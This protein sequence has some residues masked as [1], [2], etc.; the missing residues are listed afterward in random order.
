MLDQATRPAPGNEC[1]LLSWMPLAGTGCGLF[2][3]S[4]GSQAGE[5][6]RVHGFGQSFHHV[7]DSGTVAA[8]DAAVEQ[9]DLFLLYRR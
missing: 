5:A 9:E 3:H 1:D 4:F 2:K 8:R 7:D 6:V